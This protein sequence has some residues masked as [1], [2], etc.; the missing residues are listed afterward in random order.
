[1]SVSDPQRPV[2]E[3]LFDIFLD[4]ARM[5]IDQN[6]PT[7]CLGGSG[8]VNVT[9]ARFSFPVLPRPHAARGDDAVDAIRVHGAGRGE[10]RATASCDPRVSRV[11]GWE[12]ICRR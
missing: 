8:T 11:G 3:H 9:D 4:F 6:A 2:Y 12:E 1:M 5:P 7:N 10:P